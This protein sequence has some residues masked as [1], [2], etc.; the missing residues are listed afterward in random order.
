MIKIAITG[1]IASGKSTV[2]KIL[3][4]LQYKTID[5]D[6]I[7]HDLLD[8][9]R[10]EIKKT[11]D[12]YDIEEDGKISREKLGALVFGDYN[13]KSALEGI[14][15]PKIKDEINLFFEKNKDQKAVFVSVPLLYETGMEKMFDKVLFIYSP[16]NYRLERLIKRNG[17][18]QEYAKQR[19]NSQWSQLDKVKKADYVL[20]NDSDVM[21]LTIQVYK[22][23]V[24]VIF[25]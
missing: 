13:L 3:S 24:L 12:G 16:D 9:H 19:M 1:N 2:E 10:L 25:L 11:F 21:E 17:Y 5:T 14:L 18:S 7:A 15:H 23:M 6:K 4:D 22:A 8:K 20:Y